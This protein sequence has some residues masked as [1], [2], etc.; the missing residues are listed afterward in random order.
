MGIIDVGSN[1]VRLVLYERLSRAPTVF[2]NEKV[3]A[4]LGRGVAEDG[5]LHADGMEIAL[6]AIRRFCQIAAQVGVIRLDVV[7]TAATRD[8]SNGGA[9]IAEIE[10]ITGGSVR[11]LSGAEEAEMAALG[12]VCGFHEPDGVVGD[13]GGG[14]L[15]LISVRGIGLGDGESFPL[16]VLRLVEASRNAPRTAARIVAGVI[17]KSSA[18]AALEGRDF[19]AVG[20]TWRSLA[21]L[22]MAQADYPI[23]IMHGYAIEAEEAV[24]FCRSLTTANLSAIDAIGAVSRQRRELLPFGAAVL[25]EILRQGRPRRVVISALGVREGYLYSQLTMACEDL[26]VLRAR[27]PR[28]S[29]ELIGWTGDLF[30]VMGIEETPEERRLRTAACLLAD[31]S[32]R[33]HPDY[34]GDQAVAIVGNSAFSG[35]DHAGRGYLA[36]VL[37]YRYAGFVDAEQTPHVRE[38]V[39]TRLKSQARFLAAMLRLAYV[40]SASMPGVIPRISFTLEGECLVMH[41]PRD[42][43]D[44]DGQRVRRRFAQLAELLDYGSAVLVTEPAAPRANGTP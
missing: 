26:A 23:Q 20:G 44:L 32:W 9:F 39:P 43:V 7:A 41:L 3:L 25:G 18:L 37:Y 15:E 1:S 17:E 10:A 11:L 42:L 8:A 28:H 30:R 21:R 6:S 24:Q 2:F 19:F 14:S 5:R 4:G 38:L 40:L 33:A 35:I 29:A 13:L 31:I 36:L 12:V 34:R 16:G 22:H 27:S